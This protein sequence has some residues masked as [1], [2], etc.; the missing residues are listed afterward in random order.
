MESDEGATGPV[1]VDT[2]YNP[3]PA[4]A[5]GGYFSAPDG[6]RLRMSF[7]SGR[8]AAGGRV[9]IVSYEGRGVEDAR[10]LKARIRAPHC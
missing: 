3:V 10:D 4:G 7:L 8:E 2:P 5:E 1:L 6:T 9:G